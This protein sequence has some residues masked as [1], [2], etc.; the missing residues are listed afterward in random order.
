MQSLFQPNLRACPH[1]SLVAY[2]CASLCVLT[3]LQLTRASQRSVPCIRCRRQPRHHNPQLIKG[4]RCLQAAAP[5]M[6]PPPPPPIAALDCERLENVNCSSH[7]PCARFCSSSRHHKTF[8]NL[9]TFHSSAALA[10][11][12]S[13][14]ELQ[15][16]AV[17][18]LAAL[19]YGV[20]GSE[21]LQQMCASVKCP[22][23]SAASAR[24]YLTSNVAVGA[25]L[26]RPLAF[27]MVTLTVC[28]R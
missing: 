14:Q 21:Q 20:A 26:V 13:V 6:P 23:V 11:D 16:D 1:I 12:I 3:V 8:H 27:R 25:V 22:L 24:P 2:S 9:K 28:C 18:A 15:S 5:C 19:V 7:P 4:V 10:W 17:S